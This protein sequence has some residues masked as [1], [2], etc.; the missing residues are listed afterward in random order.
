MIEVVSKKNYEGEGVYIG[1]GAGGVV[2][3][4]GYG[5]YGNPVAI[6]KQCPVCG[7]MHRDGGSTLPCYRKYLWAR[8]QEKGELY[9]GMKRLAEAHKAGQKVVLICWCKPK[10]CHG[11]VL[12]GAIEW[13]AI[14]WVGNMT[15]RL[16]SCTNGGP[17]DGHIRISD[18]IKTWPQWVVDYIVAHE[19]AHRIHPNHSADFWEFL[20]AAYPLTERAR[21]FIQGVG[22]ARDL[23]YEEDA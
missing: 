5:M 1:R 17:T 23:S 18:K 15:T 2:T 3:E 20:M 7:K 11:D 4:G 10:P 22:F 6:G 21:G 13:M 8:M 16:G 14:R 12:K 9:W 19:L